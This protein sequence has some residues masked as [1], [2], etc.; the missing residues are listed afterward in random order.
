MPRSRQ[1]WTKAEDAILG[2][3]W[4]DATVQISGRS[5]AALRNRALVLGITG[6]RRKAWL[7]PEVAALRRIVERHSPGSVWTKAREVR[8]GR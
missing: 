6:R 5:R 4:P 8:R 3:R 2:A 1:P 7:Q